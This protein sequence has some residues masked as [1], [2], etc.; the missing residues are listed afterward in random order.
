MENLLNLD[1]ST[2]LA[3]K[4][5]RLQ[6]VYKIRDKKK[7]LQNLRF[8]NI[9]QAIIRSMEPNLDRNGNILK[10]LRIFDLKFRQ[11]GVSTFWLLWWL[12]DAIF[13]RN[14]INGILADKKEN[15]NY[16]F[17]IVRLAH[18][19]MPSTLQPRLGE[20]SKSALSFEDINSKIMVS[21]SFKSTAIHSLHVS[22]LCYCDDIELQRTFGACSP[23]SNITLE[24]TG[25][26]V[27]NYGYELYQEGKK[28]ESE[29]K[30]DFYAWPIQEEYR[31]P[32][33][34]I[35]RETI[36]GSLTHEERKFMAFMKNLYSIDVDMEQILFR[37]TKQKELKG[38]YRQEFPETDED[39][40]L[41]SGHKFF[42]PRK[43]HRLIRNAKDIEATNPPYAVS[44]TGDWVQWAAPEKGH[45]YVA[46]A[47]TSD[48]G[49]D[50]CYLKIIDVTAAK[51]VFRFRA[52]CGID[53]FYRHLDKWGRIY[54]R[55]LLAVERNNHG[56]AVIL[57]LRETMRYPNLYQEEINP[58]VLGIDNK[59]PKFGWITDKTSKP[60]ML[61]ELKWAIEG[62]WDQDEGHFDSQ[63]LVL[64]R[65]F[66][67][68][69]MT[70][71]NVDGKLESIAGK[72]DDGVIATAIAY[73]MY[74]RCRKYVAVDGGGKLPA[75]LFGGS[76]E[77][78]DETF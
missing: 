2:Q 49:E 35:S 66:L 28:N 18:D 73:Q 51:E 68:E 24:S 54:N 47:D 64:D 20:D 59:T 34:G 48:M 44:D 14:T 74:K 17:E 21:L 16:L 8:N 58:N 77:V 55:A 43:L 22:E 9:Q 12:D 45:I 25:N 70:F 30:A 1:P 4:F 67:E 15:L 56:H 53:Y 69:C 50:F 42:N 37:R 40:F 29:Y 39:A 13:T 27:G 41:S 10:P 46:G 57:G 26:G 62:E 71:E 32:L 60:V 6:N 78:R 36:E 52:R 63:F 61:D 3:N 75:F 65:I 31:H 19:N 5:W 11:G 23:D 33:N 72:H 76:R 7:N 38:L